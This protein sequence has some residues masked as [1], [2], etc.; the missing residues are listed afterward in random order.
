MK[1][2]LLFVMA[3]A[4]LSATPPPI[5]VAHRATTEREH[6]FSVALP[7][8]GAFGLFEPIG[9]KKWAEGWQPVFVSEADADLHDGSVFTVDRPGEGGAPI[10]SVWTITRYEPGRVIEY[11]NVLPGIRATRIIVR[12][13]PTSDTDT[14][15]T[16]RYTYHS[17]STEGDAAITRITAPAFRDMID[18]W[19]TAIADYLKRGTPA[20]P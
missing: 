1:F 13:E 10:T 8:A 2:L 18:G 12:C 17:L 20:S 3:P 16:V 15:V 7:V 6:T 11:R 14:R 9:E 4:F 5:P 19:G